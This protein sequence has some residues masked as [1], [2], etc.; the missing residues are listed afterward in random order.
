MVKNLSANARNEGSGRSPG[1]ENGHPLHCSCLEY[2]VDRG[3]WQAIVNG[4]TKDR[5]RLSSFD[6]PREGRVRR[7]NSPL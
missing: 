5:I 4:I 1:R 3:A 2:P 6:S 7:K